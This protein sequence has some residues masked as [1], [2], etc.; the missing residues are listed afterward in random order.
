MDS[1]RLQTPKR[2]GETPFEELPNLPKPVIPQI[3]LN[4]Q[5]MDINGMLKYKYGAST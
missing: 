3:D 1:S 4:I 5:R 2:D